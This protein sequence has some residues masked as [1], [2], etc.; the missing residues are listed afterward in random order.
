M[1]VSKF[2]AF[3]ATLALLFITSVSAQSLAGN[4]VPAE[5]PPSSF[6]G[7]QYVDS[8]GCVFIRA[9]ISGN[10][11]WVPRVSRNR[12][13]VCG[14]QPSLKG[15][16]AAAPAQAV[17]TKSAPQPV[18]AP[19]PKPKAV[20]K[21]QTP[22]Q[23]TTKAAT[24]VTGQTAGATLTPQ[25]PR[26]D[27]QGA[28]NAPLR[29]TATLP[30]AAAPKTQTAP[31]AQPTRSQPACRG[32]S[33]LSSKYINAGTPDNP[34][35]CGPQQGNFFGQDVNTTLGP[36]SSLDVAPRTAP[37]PSRG[38]VRLSK[39]P[40]SAR[41]TFDPPKG[42]RPVW[43]DD[44]LNPR[45]GLETREGRAA[46]NRIWTQ[47]VPR[48]LLKNNAAPQVTRAGN[49]PLRL[50]FG[51]KSTPASHRF[52]QVGTYGVKGNASRA[53][54]RLTAA[55]LPAKIGRATRGGKTYQ[56][57]LAGPFQDQS[58]LRAALQGARSAGFRDAFLRK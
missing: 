2:A 43:D 33:A 52:V 45:R 36:Q 31:T 40:A 42:Y 8:K 27:R 7:N 4:T 25:T 50:S 13:I 6:K 19:A 49:D 12:Q 51:T 21:A 15:A 9:G 26:R 58:A 39:V 16:T 11:T 3:T 44:R 34:V 1:S 35:R 28:T 56:V 54:Q 24:P 55:G 47:K 18:R 46:S 22:V 48:K 5:F 37:D 30:S 17:P 32:A 53:A 41:V 10:T 14:F 23:P 57:V 29:T 20:A 38:V